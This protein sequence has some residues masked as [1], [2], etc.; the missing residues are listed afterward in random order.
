MNM[1][2]KLITGVLAFAVVSGVAA[3]APPQTALAAAANTTAPK[4]TAAKVT[5]DPYAYTAKAG[6]NYTLLARKAVQTYGIREKVHLSLAQIVAAETFLSSDAGFPE[7]NLGQ[8][9]TFKAEDVKAVVKK[10]QALTTTQ[11]AAWQAYVPNVDF[12][13]RDNG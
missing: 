4:A 11:K 6:D 12:D 8:A 7:L 1:I 13:T 5:P 10:V 9:V 3:I 2:R